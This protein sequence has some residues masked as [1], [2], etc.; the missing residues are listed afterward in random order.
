[1]L[2][3]VLDFL[4]PELDAAEV[5]EIALIPRSFDRPTGQLL[6]VGRADGRRSL[7]SRPAEFELFREIP[8]RAEAP[9]ALV[10]DD[11]GARLEVQ[12]IDGRVLRLAL[13]DGEVESVEAILARKK[14][15][16]SR[17]ELTPRSGRESRAARRGT[18]RPPESVE[19]EVV[20]VP[21]HLLK[22]GGTPV[23]EPIR[24]EGAVEDL[25]RKILM[26][27]SGTG[28]APSPPPPGR[29]PSPRPPSPRPP[30]PRPPSPR[31]SPRPGMEPPTSTDSDRPSAIPPAL[32]PSREALARVRGETEPDGERESV[33]PPAFTPAPMP[34]VTSPRDTTALRAR[35]RQHWEHGE[36]DE[37]SQ[38]ARVLAFLGSADPTEKRLA[39]L[40]GD[41]SPVLSTPLASHLFKAYVAHDDEDPDMARL[42]A[43][44][45][46]A[47]L[48]MR[49]RPER[50]LGLR[51]RDLVDAAGAEAGF[52]GTFR[53]AARGLGLPAPRLWLRTDLPGGLAYLNVSPIGSLA[54]GSIASSFSYD[55]MLFVAG[56]HLAFYRPEVYLLA[57]LPSPSDLLT[58]VCAGLYLERRMPADPRIVKVA[59]SIERFMV[60]QVRE[61][62]RAACAELSLPSVGDPRTH[63]ADALL[64]FRRASHLS[65]ARAGFCLTGSIAVSARM[66]RL[67]PTPS[68]LQVEE[69]VDD[70]ASYA[71]SRAWLTLRRELGIALAPSAPEIPI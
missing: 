40:A 45:W 67:L 7:L 44:L 56:H 28:A 20:V 16:S 6:F 17:P 18:L 57:L 49:L 63:I 64:R 53:R 69:L 29:S 15:R 68:G 61:S 25:A 19:A 11:A 39:S 3:D 58:L 54:G 47:L 55:E 70:L 31:S 13:L 71:V 43:A 50:D 23:P 34:A 14:R 26:G 66:V 27:A 12:V 51:P 32:A 2:D 37:A 38:V 8:V 60:P 52:G 5:R 42:T 1:M 24:G 65:A 22:K 35:L 59:E 48:T 21:D 9:F 33:R 46:P 62:L 36:L 4:P 10:K 30:S 41:Q